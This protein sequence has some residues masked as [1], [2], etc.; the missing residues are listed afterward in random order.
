MTPREQ[1]EYTVLRATIRERGTARVW[2]FCAGLAVWASLTLVT[3][4]LALPPVTVLVPLT[5][6][7]ATFEAV[8]ALH[9]SVERLGRFLLVFHDDSWERAAGSFGRPSGAV[10]A[11]ALFS[12]MFYIAALVNLAPLLLTSPIIQELILVG[13]AHAVFVARV[14]VARTAARR[15]RTVDRA[16][17]EELRAGSDA[18]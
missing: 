6:L 4:A 12:G 16:R 3:F 13:V 1:I 11:D 14:I 18:V 7:A 5:T 2:I 17:F 8:F 9:V 10:A 15:Q